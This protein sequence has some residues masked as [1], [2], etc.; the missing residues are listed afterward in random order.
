MP[1]QRVKTSVRGQ[2]D[3][4]QYMEAYDELKTGMSLRRA[5]EKYNINY[6]SLLRYKRK[7]EANKDESNKSTSMGYNAH[8]RVFTDS[9][10]KS[11][12][13][14]LIL[15][16][17]VRLGLSPKEARKFSYEWAVKN[18]LKRPSTWDSNGIAGED[19]LR[20]FLG[21]NPEL[22][23]RTAEETS[24]SWEKS[25][26]MDPRLENMKVEIEDTEL[27]EPHTEFVQAS[28]QSSIRMEDVDTSS[29][30]FPR[31]DNCELFGKYIAEELRA[32]PYLK[33]LVLQEKI[34]NCFKK[35]I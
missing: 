16:T 23:I 25:F 21:R 1:R 9:Q 26:N 35:L 15:C 7:R 10:E 28:Y 31:N 8:N 27:L 13:T 11:L 4:S 22:S 17:D 5:A 12:T 33:R 20:G 6:V 24:V 14:Y 2:S 18:K 3:I 19:W 34:I 32:L 30:D 29:S